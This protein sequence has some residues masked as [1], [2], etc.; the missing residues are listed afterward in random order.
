MFAPSPWG[1]PVVVSEQSW[2]CT[3]PVTAP[4]GPVNVAVSV[5]E[6]PKGMLGAL[7]WV[8]IVGKGATAPAAKPISMPPTPVPSREIIR[9]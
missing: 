9:T 2:N 3:V 4:L 1:H 6:P 7:T 8:A 5:N